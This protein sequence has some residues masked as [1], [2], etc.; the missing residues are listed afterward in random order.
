MVENGPQSLPPDNWVSLRDRLY[1][2]ANSLELY[3][4]GYLVAMG[5]LLMLAVF[6]FVFAQQVT[7]LDLSARVSQQITA[8][9]N[10]RDRLSNQ[11]QSESADLAIKTQKMDDA[12]EKVLDVANQDYPPDRHNGDK[13]QFINGVRGANPVVSLDF[14]ALVSPSL[15][16]IGT[17]MLK[18]LSI[19]NNANAIPMAVNIRWMTI[20]FLTDTGVR[21]NW[22]H[23]GKLFKTES[24]P[25]T[26]DELKD[27]DSLQKDI[28]KRDATLDQ[29]DYQIKDL[30]SQKGTANNLEKLHLVHEELESDKKWSLIQTSVT[31]FGTLAVLMFFIAIISELHRYTLRLAMFYAAQADALNLLHNGGGVDQLEK[32]STIFSPRTNFGK[33]PATPFEQVVDALAA[34][35]KLKDDSSK[36]SE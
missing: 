12:I 17:E 15:E 26:P 22:E 24:S 14:D 2:R 4:R 6:V 32:L 9:Q 13:T 23:L 19:L 30:T 35:S 11:I 28:A 36:G 21:P 33:Q 31:R 25:L 10:S 34:V 29:F 18:K 3:S 1:T 16:Q 5:L 20:S 27:V 7:D 8:F